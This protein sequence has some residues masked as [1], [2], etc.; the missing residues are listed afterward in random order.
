MKTDQ[1]FRHPSSSSDMLQ[2]QIGWKIAPNLSVFHE[3]VVS[4]LFRWFRSGYDSTVDLPVY[5]MDDVDFVFLLR[6]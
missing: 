2:R 6:G 5:R 1:P 4:H 3:G